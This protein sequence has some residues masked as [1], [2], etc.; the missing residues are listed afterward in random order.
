MGKQRSAA[1][2]KGS[3][4]VEKERIKVK[5]RDR[6]IRIQLERCVLERCD[7]ST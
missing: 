3:Y 4:S 7:F 1:S 2:D 5:A 6:S